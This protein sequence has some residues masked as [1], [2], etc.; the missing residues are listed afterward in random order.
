MQL[1]LVMGGEKVDFVRDEVT[2]SAGPVGEHAI[3]VRD[4]VTARLERM[5]VLAAPGTPCQ[6]EVVVLVPDA[7]P[8]CARAA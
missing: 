7:D 8:G 5:E 4:R 2:V 6:I 3:G 1:E